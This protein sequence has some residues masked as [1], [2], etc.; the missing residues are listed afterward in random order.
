MQDD[1]IRLLYVEYSF[2]GNHG[3]DMETVSVEKPKTSNQ[4]IVYN[5]KKSISLFLYKANFPG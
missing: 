1:E 5:Y 2:L 3:E 4:E